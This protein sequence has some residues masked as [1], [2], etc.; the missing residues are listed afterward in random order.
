MTTSVKPEY[1]F[2]IKVQD[3]VR[4]LTIFYQSLASSAA[5]LSSL[6]PLCVC[7]HACVYAYMR[8]FV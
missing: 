6:L 3:D 1:S 2:K 7:V 5:Y 4:R 8:M